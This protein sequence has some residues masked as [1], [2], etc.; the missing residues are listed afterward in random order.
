[1]DKQYSHLNT[2]IRVSK[3]TILLSLMIF[4]LANLAYANLDEPDSLTAEQ[5]FTLEGRVINKQTLE[6]RFNIAPGYLL[7]REHFK[8]QDLNGQSLN[9]LPHVFPAA[10]TKHDEVLG[11]YQAYTNH[12]ALNIPLTALSNTKSGL[13][14]EY[15]GCSD[16]GFCYAPAAKQ[17]LLASDGTIQITDVSTDVFTKSESAT[18][19][20]ASLATADKETSNSNTNPSTGS[21]SDFLTNQLKTGAFP[22]TFLLFLGLG[23]L[24]AFTPCVLPMVPILAN[25]LVGQDTPLSS[26]RAAFL[27]SIYVFSVA[28]CYALAGVLA[29]YMGSY[30]Q[31][32]L[33]KPVVLISLSF[34]LLLFALSQFNL[35]HIQLPQFLTQTLHQ[36]QHKQKQGSAFGALAMGI[37]SALVVSPCVTPA[38]VGALS[39]IGQTGNAVLGGLALFAL[40]LGMGLPL[41]CVACVGGHYLPKAG[42]WMGRIKTITGVL[43]LLLAASF[44]V[45]ALPN[46]YH[47][48]AESSISTHF[49][50]IRTKTDLES[51]LKEAQ[52]SNT[53]VI[54]DVY[55][56]WCISCQ[57]IDREL[58]ANNTVLST[59]KNA[60]LLRLDMTKQ[61]Q[62]VELLQKDL[63]IIGPPTLL[64]FNA[65]GLEDKNYRLIGKVESIDFIN[66][67]N[68]FLGL[69]KK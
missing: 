38:L 16:S 42:P 47:S 56:D 67:V 44:L 46:F 39:Y 69:Q 66:H 65:N 63:G 21:E 15:Q 17:V 25:I 28:I 18:T 29:G 32:S 9:K 2:L 60:K 61:T 41:L 53:P 62:A 40:A 4:G 43:L 26:R 57:Q 30:L 3:K 36:L 19:S 50:S 68:R 37:L 45:R 31:I 58:F 6:L 1:M 22:I 59:L 14:V 10:L 64:F 8:L 13:Q 34:L 48:N 55:A 49:T 52:A 12:V 33:Q 51:A 20:T 7:Y 24:L 54:L 27:A 11:D 5:A 23:L 35:I